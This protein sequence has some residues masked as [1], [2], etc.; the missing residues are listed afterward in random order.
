MDFSAHTQT[1]VQG[2]DEHRDAFSNVTL[3]MLFKESY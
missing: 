2:E 3:S 1:G